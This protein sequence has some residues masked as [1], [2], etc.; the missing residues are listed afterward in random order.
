MAL[1]HFSLTCKCDFK[2]G[3][4][5]LGTQKKKKKKERVGGWGKGTK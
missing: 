3:S 2:K 5:S 4:R 1:K